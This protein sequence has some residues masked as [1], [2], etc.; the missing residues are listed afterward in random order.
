MKIYFAG[1][2]GQESRERKWQRTIKKRLLS[3][4][5]ILQDEFSVPYAFD[6]IKN[7]KQNDTK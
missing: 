1:A 4:Y 3:F 2:P 5:N 7:K 6:L